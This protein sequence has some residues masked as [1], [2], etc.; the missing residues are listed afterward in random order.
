MADKT[1][2]QRLADEGQSP[3]IDYL[4]RD[5]V[6]SGELE[7]LIREHGIRGVT[8]NPTIFQKAISAGNAYDE[9][10]REVFQETDEP[11][12]IFIKLAGRDVKDACDLLRPYWNEGCR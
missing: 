10:I 3:W 12:D 1:P 11:K 7:R 2:L 8:S 6:E 5:L 4:S 9:Q